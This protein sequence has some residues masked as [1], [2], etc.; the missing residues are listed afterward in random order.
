M[1]LRFFKYLLKRNNQLIKDQ[2][3][4]QSINQSI[5]RSIQTYTT[6]QNFTILLKEFTENDSTIPFLNGS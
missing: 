2:S 4:N 6:R 3:I 1:T 5:D